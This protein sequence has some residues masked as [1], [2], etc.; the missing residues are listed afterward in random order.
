M[1]H[2]RGLSDA[3][4]DSDR[5]EKVA[6]YQAIPTLQEYLLVEQDYVCV[7]HWQRQP[8]GAWTAH[9]YTTLE[10]VVAFPTLAVTLPL[11]E[12]YRDVFDS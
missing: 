2:H 12:V 11:R 6:L 7:E 3:T 1:C 5:G 8:T 10:A 4:R 9:T